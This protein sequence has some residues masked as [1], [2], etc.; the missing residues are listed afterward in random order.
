MKIVIFLSI[1]AQYG[2]HVFLFF[3]VNI[4]TV[5]HTCFLVLPRYIDT[6]IVSIY[7]GGDMI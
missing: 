4:R 1:Y 3:F 7:Q 2:V 6:L 5:R